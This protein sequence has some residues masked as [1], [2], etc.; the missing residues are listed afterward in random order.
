MFM[1]QITGVIHLSI[2]VIILFYVNPALLQNPLGPI[3]CSL[4]LGLYVWF[5]NYQQHKASIMRLVYVPSGAHKELFESWI[6]SCGVDVARIQL[7][8][9]YT[10]EQCTMTMGNTIIIDPIC[11]SVCDGDAT[12]V[13]VKSIFHQIIEPSLSEN[14]KK[15]LAAYKEFLTPEAQAFLFKHEVGH[16]VH[17][18]AAKKLCL[19][20]LSGVMAAYVGIEVAKLVL[21]F[22]GFLAI[23]LGMIVGG[24]LDLLLTYATN[25]FFKYCAEKNADIFAARYCS[26]D[27][28]IA[29]AQFF[30]KIQEINETFKDPQN[31]LNR[32]PSALKG[33]PEGKTRAA[34]LLK[35]AKEDRK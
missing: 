32:L 17:R 5:L 6:R 26:T 20:F 24:V 29:A 1:Q 27:E 28:I 11:C 16:V 3:I 35:L 15:R 7:R 19:I 34:Y 13:P 18:F 2:P 33:Y 23:L 14:T 25:L 9:A 31:F 22:N 4:V 30:A 8:Y 10:A 12:I 21:V